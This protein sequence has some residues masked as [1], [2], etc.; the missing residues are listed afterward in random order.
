MKKELKPKVEAIINF[1]KKRYKAEIII[2]VGSRVVG[3]YKPN[4]DWDI[5][6]FTRKKILKETVQ[7]VYDSY[8]EILKNDDLDIYRNSFDKSSFPSKLYRDLRNS[9]VIL[10]TKDGFG[11]KLREKSLKLYKKGPD[12]WTKDYAQGRFY[13]A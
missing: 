2:I 9:E 11:K 6:I 10:D 1:L 5:Y 13:K 4:S 12:K 8:P 7:E 3:D